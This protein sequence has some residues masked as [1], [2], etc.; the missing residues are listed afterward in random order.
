MT[1]MHFRRALCFHFLSAKWVRLAWS[2]PAGIFGIDASDTFIERGLEVTF[3]L[4]M[5]GFLGG[6]GC[7]LWF[8]STYAA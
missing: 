7:S 8:F 5:L 3:W 1:H 4:T 6:V 2:Q